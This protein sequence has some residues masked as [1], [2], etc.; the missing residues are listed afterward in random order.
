[1][2]SLLIECPWI[3]ISSNYMSVNSLQHSNMKASCGDKGIWFQYA[4][5]CFHSYA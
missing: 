2:E 4:P 1:M 3:S 5:L